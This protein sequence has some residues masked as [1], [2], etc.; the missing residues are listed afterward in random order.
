MVSMLIP[1]GKDLH[2]C[3]DI[4]DS[5][6]IGVIRLI[7]RWFEGIGCVGSIRDRTYVPF[8]EKRLRLGGQGE[9]R[10]HGTAEA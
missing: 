5:V 6:G 10:D 8:S 2:A 7:I 4:Q 1:A 9:W 3:A